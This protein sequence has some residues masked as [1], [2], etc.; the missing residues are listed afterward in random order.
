MT[1]RRDFISDCCFYGG[2]DR[3][4]RLEDLSMQSVV[5]LSPYVIHRALPSE[6]SEIPHMAWPMLL[7]HHI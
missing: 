5:S 6:R 2:D 3:F 1:D 4:W 7:M